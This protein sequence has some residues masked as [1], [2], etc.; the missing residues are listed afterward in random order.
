MLIIVIWIASIF[1]IYHLW[2]NVS[3]KIG[4][5]ILLTIAMILF[6]MLGL[7]IYWVYYFSS[8]KETN[9]NI[10]TPQLNGMCNSGNSQVVQNAHADTDDIRLSRFEALI[11]TN[12]EFLEQYNILY[13]IFIPK[14]DRNYK[15]SLTGLLDEKTRVKKLEKAHYT[16]R[17]LCN[18]NADDYIAFF[19]VFYDNILNEMLQSKYRTLASMASV[20]LSDVN[21]GDS[22]VEEYDLRDRL[23]DFIQDPNASESET[24]ISTE[25]G[26]VRFYIK[27]KNGEVCYKAKNLYKTTDDGCYCMTDSLIRLAEILIAI[28]IK[29]EFGPKAVIS[30]KNIETYNIPNLEWIFDGIE[31][32]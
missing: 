28:C 4:L 9:S 30:R 17:S 18:G 19:E 29:Y 1:S 20:V 31:V 14:S 12:K 26:T 11:K 22:I 13:D 24:D 16:I 5:K 15:G 3:G 6:S 23:V 7:I 32:E 25:D 2:K 27:R 8:N 10:T 21:R